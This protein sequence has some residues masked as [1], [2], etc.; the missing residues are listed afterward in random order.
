M[1]W[2]EDFGNNKILPTPLW[3]TF[4]ERDDGQLFAGASGKYDP[5]PIRIA[6]LWRWWT[7]VLN[8]SV[9]DESPPAIAG[10]GGVCAIA[11]TPDRMYLGGTFYTGIVSYSR[12]SASASVDGRPVGG[13]V[14]D[15]GFVWAILPIGDSVL[16]GGNFIS[17]DG[18]VAS[19]GFTKADGTMT[20]TPLAKPLDQRALVRTLVAVDDRVAVGGTFASASGTTLNSIGLYDLK[21]KSWA[22][23]GKVGVERKQAGSG[24]PGSVD[25]IRRAGDLLLVGGTFDAA[26]GVP[27]RGVAVYDLKKDAWSDLD[28]GVRGA[29]SAILPQK[30]RWFVGGL[31][32]EVGKAPV[33]SSGVAYWDVKAAKW[34]GMDA[35]VQSTRPFP[36]VLCLQERG[37]YVLVAGEFETAGSKGLPFRNAALWE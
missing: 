6:S 35:G 28:G 22:P 37:P 18:A 13:G 8:P 9:I 29:V 24:E 15:P 4:A 27:A 5:Q 32:F 25:V 7:P 3:L 30:D 12:G 14:F 11:F 36:Q 34:V 33:A 10:V 2:R 19:L 31:F 1:P 17:A 20:W 21:K 16:V 26:G 23:C